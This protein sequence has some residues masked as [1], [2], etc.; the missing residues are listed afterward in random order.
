[1]VAVNIFGWDYKP[2]ERELREVGF[3]DIRRAQFCSVIG[4]YPHFVPAEILCEEGLIGFC[5]LF[6][7]SF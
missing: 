2:I 6:I 7:Y 3:I 1:L 4:I 5:F